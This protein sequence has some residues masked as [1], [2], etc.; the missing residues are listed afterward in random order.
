MTYFVYICTYLLIGYI[1]GNVITNNQY[2]S[3]AEF[4]L[5]VIFWPAILIL[6]IINVISYLIV[7][8]VAKAVMKRR[9]DED[10]Y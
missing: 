4:L 10:E 2:K 8:A 1:I 3:V 7:L 5:L 6:A 9:R